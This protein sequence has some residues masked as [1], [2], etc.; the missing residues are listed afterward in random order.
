MS[1]AAFVSKES[2]PERQF[3][4]IDNFRIEN[5]SELTAFTQAQNISTRIESSRYVFVSLFFFEKKKFKF[6]FFFLC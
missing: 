5:K 6:F 1:A 4:N 2:S 3:D